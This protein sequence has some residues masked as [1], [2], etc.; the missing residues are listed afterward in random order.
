MR[1]VRALAAPMLALMESMLLNCGLMSEYRELWIVQLLVSG[2]Q[3]FERQWFPESTA[4]FLFPQSH[5]DQFQDTIQTD[6]NQ[7]NSAFAPREGF[8]EDQAQI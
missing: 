6:E 7:I 4:L 1:R 2:Q 3:E 8:L 5:N